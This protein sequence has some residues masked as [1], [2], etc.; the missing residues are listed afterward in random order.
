MTPVPLFGHD[1]LRSRLAASVDAGRLP[2]ALAFV[3]PAG[4]GKQRLAL[5]LGQRLL[6]TA[7][8]GKPCGKCQACAW[9]QSLTHPDLTWVFPRPRLKDSDASADMVW[10]DLSSAIAERRDAGWLYAPASGSDAIYV[11]TVRAL[12]ARMALTPAMG[13]RKVFVI[14]DAERMVPQEGAEAAANAFLKALEEPPADTTIILTTSAPDALLP[15][16]RSRVVLIRVSPLND[17]ALRAFVAHET[18]HAR[19]GT[20]GTIDA[21]VRAAAGAPGAL[22]ASHD[23]RAS[24]DGARAMLDA[25]KQDLYRVALRQGAAGARGAFAER[26]DALTAGLHTR[27]RDAVARGENERAQR[28]IESITRVEQAKELLENNV[29]PQL[30]TAVLLMGMRP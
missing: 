28:T 15:T 25:T 5:W 11:S 20:S 9:A 1:T 27:A 19:L 4:I 12:V 23:V 17:A 30:I 13:S 3:G 2:S 7:P 26:L 29:N 8:S 6:C 16:I 24:A 21:V 22:I 10:D 18:V 14:G